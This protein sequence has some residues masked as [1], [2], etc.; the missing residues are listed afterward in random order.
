[1][2][3]NMSQIKDLLLPGLRA[4]TGD[5]KQIETQY[6]NVFEITKSNM[7]V[8]R[9]ASMQYLAFAQLKLEGG[10]TTFDNTPGQRF[11]Y[12]QSHN[13]IGLGYAITRK[14]IDDN[15]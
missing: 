15:L 5:Y 3:V 6:T 7:E 14:S 8:E 10:P 12:N 13:E 4:V 9:T 2:A 1:M 11:V